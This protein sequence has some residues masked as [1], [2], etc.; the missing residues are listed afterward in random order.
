MRLTQFD[1]RSLRKP[2]NQEGI[3]AVSRLPGFLSRV[4]RLCLLVLSCAFPSRAQAQTAQ[5]VKDTVHNLSASGP[6]AIRAQ[7]E[8][9]VCIFCHTPHGSAG[10]EPL[11]NRGIPAGPYTIYESTSLRATVGQ[12]TGASK[13]CLSCHDGTIAL[14]SVLSRAAPIA[15]TGGDRMPAGRSNLGTDLGDDHPVSFAYAGSL[16][17]TNSELVTPGA[18]PP[19]VRLDRNGELQCTA[20][21]EPHDNT[22]G[23]FLVRS[24]ESSSLCASCHRPLLWSSS[25]HATSNAVVTADA[26]AALGTDP[27]PTR[28]NACGSC[29]RPHGAGG[30]PW[31]LAGRSITAT[32][33]P[34]HNGTV[35]QRNV[36]AEL[37]K[38]ST[39]GI[40]I[41]GTPG[42]VG[43]PFLEGATVS[44]ADCHDPH[45]AGSSEGSSS[46]LPAS[47]A[48]MNG[49]A[50]NGVALPAISH[51]HELCF[52]C[53]G[54]APSRVRNTI[55]RV[56]I[57]PNKRLQ[58]QTNN[59]SFHPVGNPGPSA[60]V[61]SLIPP[62]TTASTME[63]GD[64]HSSDDT[65]RLGGS[66]PAG[67]HGS[68]YAPLLAQRYDT[69][70]G[71]I[72]SAAAYAL[73]YR[74]HQR[75]S[76]LG[77]RSFREHRRH[78]VEERT[79]CSVCHDAHGIDAAQGT[80]QRNSSLINF[81]RSVVAPDR[82]GRLEFIDRG[83]FRGQC[84]LSCH[85][86][87]H[88]VEDY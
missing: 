86:E 36:L 55:S 42:T 9:E 33:V 4:V 35:A 78:I 21:H 17:G 69:L 32:C 3:L 60:N 63:C 26:A 77:D 7:S 83:T 68:A 20:C 66:G 62:L 13:L 5:R 70:D 74:C 76:I 56:A 57:Q 23:N 28:Q 50:L 59:P 37:S 51:E 30:R 38:F 40:V 8:T 46:S 67:P 87:E 2:G 41:E 85:G 15:L 61:P 12:P 6:G 29:H 82:S 25:A 52:R 16:S 79:P 24:N 47:L 14:G 49:V 19:P 27:L 34:C 54:D 73:C 44:C 64:C 1:G 53:H 84:S 75:E 10:V 81:D 45:A 11:W 71:S 39:H 65:Q 48:R 18:I 22:F 80:S 58:F 43:G 88:N 31:I 72:E